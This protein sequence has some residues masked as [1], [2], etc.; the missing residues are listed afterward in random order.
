MLGAVCRDTMESSACAEFQQLLGCGWEDLG[1]G[2]CIVFISSIYLFFKNLGK[3][4]NLKSFIDLQLFFPILKGLIRS[5]HYMF[6]E[7]NDSIS[8]AGH[9]QL[10]ISLGLGFNTIL[11]K[12]F[13]ISEHIFPWNWTLSGSVWTAQRVDGEVWVLAW[14]VGCSWVICQVSGPW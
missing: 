6:A 3:A 14:T 7:H 10:L 1:P 5:Y 2:S 4:R 9:I 8:S 11:W 12:P 13:H